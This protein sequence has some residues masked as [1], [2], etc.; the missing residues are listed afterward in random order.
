MLN[1]TFTKKKDEMDFFI[2]KLLLL[3]QRE[4]LNLSR[5]L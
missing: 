4:I 5:F 1:I 2:E 3:F